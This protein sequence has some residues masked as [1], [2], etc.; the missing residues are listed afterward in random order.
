[1]G[2]LRGLQATEPLCRTKVVSQAQHLPFRSLSTSIRFTDLVFKVCAKTSG[3]DIQQASDHFADQMV[4][5]VGSHSVMRLL[6]CGLEAQ[7][8]WRM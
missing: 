3:Q 7:A 2:L 8:E 4:E 6:R 5:S 1:M